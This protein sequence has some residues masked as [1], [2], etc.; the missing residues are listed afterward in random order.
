MAYQSV[1]QCRFF[2]DHLLWLKTLGLKY[3]E[4][5]GNSESNP[6]V[7]IGLNPTQSHLVN[8]GGANIG[9]AYIDYAAAPPIMTSNNKW[10]AYTAILGH[11]SASAEAK[12]KFAFDA[13]NH[14][15]DYRINLTPNTSSPYDG[16][17]LG[18]DFDNTPTTWIRFG[19][20]PVN[21]MD[22]IANFNISCISHGN[23]FDMS[24][25]PDLSL[26]LGYETGTKT[27]ETRGGASLSNT[28]WR[29]PMWGDLGAWE[30]SDPN[31]ATL[32]QTL[33][34]SSRRTWSLSFSFLNKTNTFPKYNALN[35]LID[36]NETLPD[37]ETLLTSDDFFSVVWNK[38]GTALP[39]IFQP[40]KD[41]S[42]FAICKFTNNFSFQ[43]TAPNLYSVK[44][45]IREVW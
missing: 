16:F 38:V 31:S 8:V 30:L 39:F 35:R 19:L 21:E 24:H 23:Y 33:A 28:M 40:D 13:G 37:D 17:T 7:F 1:G 18:Y 9:Y 29:P 5:W 25:S 4:A 34:H 20:D 12:I 32:N 41:V 11:N 42:E 22:Y 15:P 14:V 26:T 45:K 36:Q 6:S 3:Y 27:I 10:K 44:M 43:Q 2:V